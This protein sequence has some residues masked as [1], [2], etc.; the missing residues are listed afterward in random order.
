[1]PPAPI[2][3]LDL[4]KNRF[5]EKHVTSLLRH[6]EAAVE[7]FQKT[8]WE[9]A[10][11]KTGKF[12]EAVLKALWVDVGET[13]PAGKLFKAGNIMD[14]LPHKKG[15][16]SVRLTIPRACRFV[17]EIASNRGARHDPNEIDPNEM[18]ATVAIAN[19][20]WILSEMLR[21]A[22]KGMDLARVQGIVDGLIRRRYPLI[23]EVE[24]RVYVSIKGLSARDIALLVLRHVY[25]GRLGRQQLFDTL[26]RH[27][28]KKSNANMAI[29]RLAGTVDI[30]E[31]DRYR[32]LLPGV[33][34]ADA[35]MKGRSRA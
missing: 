6:Y 25:P 3:L 29:S 18:D 7:D 1:M 2:S 19:C 8:D 5:E 14:Q 20:S 22:Q 26:E 23:E 34:A 27:Q 28:I 4:L 16:D 33:E 35:L 12:T 32:L 31:K 9:D 30:D 13:V 24:G 15:D 11:A 10:T 21:I 17:Y